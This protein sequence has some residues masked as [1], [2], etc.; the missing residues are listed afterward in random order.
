MTVN[1]MFPTCFNPGNLLLSFQTNFYRIISW[2]PAIFHSA[3][4]VHR[5]DSPLAPVLAQAMPAHRDDS[6]LAQVLAQA[7]PTSSG[8]GTGNASAS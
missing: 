7:M 3:M 8:S 6:P 5:D 2:K 1:S 4:P